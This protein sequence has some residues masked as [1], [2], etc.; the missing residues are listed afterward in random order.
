MRVG[1]VFYDHGAIGGKQSG[2][3]HTF[4]LS[5]VEAIRS[6]SAGHSFILLDMVGQGQHAP[7][8]DLPCVN[9]PLIYFKA[10][11]SVPAEV[12]KFRR[13]LRVCKK[14]IKP[15]WFRNILSFYFRSVRAACK[16]LADINKTTSVPKEKPISVLDRAV[17]DY[18]LD[19]VWFLA[20]V[21]EKVSAPFITTVWDL[22]HRVQPFFPELNAVGQATWDE[23]EFVYRF[24]L[25][26]AA[27]IVTGT[28]VGKEEIVRSYGANP[29]NIAVIPFAVPF[30]AKM[31]QS[32]SANIREKFGLFKSFLLYPAQF[33]PH[34][35]H[36]NVLMALA[37]L[38][39]AGDLSFDMVF[40]GSDKGNMDYV[41]DFARKLDLLDD[42]HFLGFVSDEDLESLYKNAFAL[43]FASF[44]GPDNLPPLEAF[45]VGCPVIASNVAG[46]T[47]QMGDAALFFD[48]KNPTEL[49]FLIKKLEKDLFLKNSLID[50]GRM[51]ALSRSNKEY[52]ADMCRLLDEFEPI[53][54]C[55]G[56]SYVHL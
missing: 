41:R 16:D 23:R 13:F 26:R 22:Q 2:G 36:I 24:I 40:V 15:L 7:E 32:E 1:V 5:I 55:W 6:Y 48:P 49:A 27:R 44:F 4:Q 28:N 45:A 21:L 9:I 37:I 14:S 53:K 38:K 46:A 20:P 56:S 31:E 10:D 34:K 47:E 30:R 3:G 19:L 18:S 17:K 54:R 43:V 29:D 8:A 25:P 52:F 42:V 39:K 35:N 51:R 11:S 33:W 50:K 12:G